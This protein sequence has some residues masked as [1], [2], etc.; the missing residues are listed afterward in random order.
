MAPDVERND[1]ENSP[2]S[3]G[4]HDPIPDKTFVVDCGHG[5]NDL[6][7]ATKVSAMERRPPVP[8]AD[9]SRHLQFRVDLDD[10]FAAWDQP[11]SQVTE[12]KTET[13]PFLCSS[14]RNAAAVNST[15]APYGGPHPSSS[16]DVPVR[17]PG[18]LLV[19]KTPTPSARQ[20]VRLRFARTP[21]SNLLP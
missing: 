14:D 19:S 21:A 20:K 3:S 12:T 10:D 6:S 11:L 8:R 4:R 18:Q 15:S 7:G 9:G 16:F 1:A 17:I 13:A 2:A 5:S